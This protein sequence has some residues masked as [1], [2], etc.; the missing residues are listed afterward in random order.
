MGFRFPQAQFHDLL[1]H[2]RLSA[3]NAYVVAGEMVGGAILLVSWWKRR[4]RQS[5]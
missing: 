1:E 4:K 3:E 2:L 5:S